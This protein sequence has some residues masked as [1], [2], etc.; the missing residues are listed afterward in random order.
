MASKKKHQPS[1]P[2]QKQEPKRPQSPAKSVPRPAVDWP[3]MANRYAVPCLAAFLAAGFLIR[4]LNLPALSLW[5]DEYVHVLRAKNVVEGAGPLLTDDNNGILYT[6]SM[7]PGFAVFGAKV[8]WARFPSV[9]FGLGM[10]YLIYRMGT[11][12][13]NRYVGLVAAFGATF[14]LYLVFWSRMGRNYAILG[15]FSLLLGYVFLRAT[16]VKATP[17]APGWWRRAGLSRR[18]TLLLPVV[19]LLSL[20]SHQLS[21]FFVFTV[22]VYAAIVAAQGVD[23]KKY[24]WMAGI[25]LP[26]L[27]AVLIPP[28][29]SVLKSILQPLLLS[30]I[31][32]WAIPDWGRLGKLFS[33]KPLEAFN[34]Y[35]NL[36]RYD[37]HWLYLPALAGLVVAF[38]VRPAAGAWLLAS[39][40]TPFLLLSF[41]FREPFLS[42]YLIFAYP[43][44]LIAAGVFFYALWHWVRSK[45][46]GLS[47]TTAYA[48]LALPFVLILAGARWTSIA[49]LA[50]ARKLEGHI[51]DAQVASWS[52]TDWKGACAFVEKSQK[53]GDLL[54]STVPTAASYYLDRNDVLWF[55]QAYYDNQSKGYKFNAPNP[56]GGPSAAS[57]E[58]LVRTVQQNPRGWLIADYYLENVFTDE[59]ALLWVYQNMHYYPESSPDGRVMVFGWDNARPRPERQNLV[60]ELGMD[61]DNMESREFHLSL[62]QELF[63][64][65]EIVL[66]ARTSGLDSNREGLVLFNGQNAA[67]LPPNNG[68]GVEEQSIPIPREWIRP[69]PNTIQILY[70]PERPRDPRKGFTL[71]FLSITGK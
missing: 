2:A 20:L 60:V 58:D 36:L 11:H 29:G 64:Q 15:F 39:F 16:E 70:E 66:T 41:V 57:F 52:F 62:P 35:N 69:G 14:S 17:D 21:F 22:G 47:N 71:Y 48:L 33:E 9:L 61:K 40:L 43:Y 37:L 24:I 6:L 32:E 49:D 63:S 8:F 54:M 30:N 23:R 44:I 67:W 34:L 46:P 38:R 27:L 4:V 65:P 51:V 12:L 68:S 59:K 5:I 42:R 45:A 25:T 31:A 19:G 10:V 7:L 13:F 53:P 26:F 28:L 55:R 18:H 56:A 50:L 1:R 3:A